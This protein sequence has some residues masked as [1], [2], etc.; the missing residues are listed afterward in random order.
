MNKTIIITTAVLI[1][2]LG[3]HYF[4]AK[5]N[6]GASA[7]KNGKRAIQPTLVD[8]NTVPKDLWKGLIAECI[9]EENREELMYATACVVR[10]R[11]NKGMWHGLV[12]MAREDLD[13]FVTINVDYLKIT[14][15]VDYG[16]KA[17]NIIKSIKNDA[18][19]D[20]TNGATHYLL[21]GEKPYWI[22]GMT[23]ICKIGKHTFYK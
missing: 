9:G 21:D 17:K 12:A 23:R 8:T 3:L 15:G 13:E 4:N 14:K 19:H 10:N 6:V 11:L 20:V 18:A 1:S 22:E 2:A 7:L 16:L 5:A